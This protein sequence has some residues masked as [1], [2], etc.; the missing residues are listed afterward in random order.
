ML[1]F[2]KHKIFRCR[3]FY[4]QSVKSYIWIDYKS[5]VEYVYQNLIFLP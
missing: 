2:I 4:F 3:I 1:T 5:N